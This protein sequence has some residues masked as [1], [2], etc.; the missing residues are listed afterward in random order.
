MKVIIIDDDNLTLEMFREYLNQKEIQNILISDPST[1]F[2]IIY[3]EKPDL[4]FIDI[5]MGPPTGR[6]IIEK[7]NFEALDIPIVVM[8]AFLTHSMKKGLT[9]HLK[10][11]HFLPKPFTLSDADKFI[12]LY[13][14]IEC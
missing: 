8:S 3:Q 4:I 1:A 6:D 7:M 11:K 10:I 5:K 12:N 9:T 14:Y 13:S 2:E